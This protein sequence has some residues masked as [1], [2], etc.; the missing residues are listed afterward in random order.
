[1][2]VKA[3]REKEKRRKG[4]VCRNVK[5][6]LQTQGHTKRKGKGEKE[7]RNDTSRKQKAPVERKL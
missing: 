5:E 1:V 4:E 2:Q 7:K 6:R 3:K